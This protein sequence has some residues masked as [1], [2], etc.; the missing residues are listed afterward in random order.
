MK[1]GGDK[2]ATRMI[3]W[4][5]VVL[6]DAHTLYRRNGFVQEGQRICND[7]DKSRELGFWKEPL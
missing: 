4:G 2:G 1:F 7:P 5:D 3:A 6:K